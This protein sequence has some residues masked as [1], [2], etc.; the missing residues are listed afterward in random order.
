M[1]MRFRKPALAAVLALHAVALALVLAPRAA[2]VPIHAPA[3]A[4]FEVR[5][6]PAP[7]AHPAAPA[8]PVVVTRPAATSQPAP[9]VAPPPA[10]T[11]YWYYCAAS[12]AYYPY[13]N[14]CPG[15]WMKVLPQPPGQP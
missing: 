12:R 9:P 15:G 13:V 10:Q 7:A 14:E 1:P 3:L 6:V 5:A 2:P 11:S 4:L 8:R